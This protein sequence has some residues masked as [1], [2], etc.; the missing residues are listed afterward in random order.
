MD[1]G[2]L[3][4]RVLLRAWADTPNGTNGLDQTY[5]A[6]RALWAKVEPVRGLA[7]RAGMATG[8]VPTHLIWLRYSEQLKAE[9]ITLTNVFDWRGHRYRVLDSINVDDAREWIRVSVKDLGTIPG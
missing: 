9:D 5:D 3:N 1:P 7:M 8:E 6:G 2:E 4:R